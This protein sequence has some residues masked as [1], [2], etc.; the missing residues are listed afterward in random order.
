MDLPRHARTGPNSFIFAYVSTEKRP[1]RRSGP[2]TGNPGSATDLYR[3]DKVTI[4]ST[5]AIYDA[6]QNYI[7]SF[8]IS[9][10]VIFLAGAVSLPVRKIKAWEERRRAGDGNVMN[11][12]TFPPLPPSINGDIGSDVVG[13]AESKGS[14]RSGVKF[15][16]N[17]YT[18]LASE[19][20]NDEVQVEI[21]AEN[22]EGN[23]A[24]I[25]HTS[26]I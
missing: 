15:G 23:N 25:N 1:C 24:D 13:S 20:K 18:K 16:G 8:V 19:V 10:F 26:E 11:S 3:T 7:Y 9:G 22:E 2:P 21:S 14:K 6:T 4:A 5:G 12:D 17:S